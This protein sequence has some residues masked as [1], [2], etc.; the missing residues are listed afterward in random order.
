MLGTPFGTRSAWLDASVS[1]DRSPLPGDTRCDVCVVGAGIAGLCSAY[2][3]TKA[4]KSVIVLDDGP[5]AGGESGRTTAHLSNE[6]DDRY[7]EIERTHGERAAR[8]C[9]DS[10]TAAITALEQIAYDEKID[11]EFQRLDGFLFLPPGESEDVLF[12][13]LAAAHRAG[14]SGV[15]R[16]SR[17]PAFDSGPALRFPDQGQFHP[18]KFLAG[19]AHA[20]EMKGCR[21]YTGTHVDDIQAVEQRLAVQSKLGSVYAQ[22]VIIATNSPFN[23]RVTMHTKQAAYRTY[24]IGARVARGSVTRALYWDT[25]DTPGDLDAP[26]HFVRLASDLNDPDGSHELLIVGGEDHHTGDAGS[27]APARWKK[28]ENWARARFASMEDVVQRWSGQI[29]EPVDAV[30]FIGPNPSGPQNVYICTGDSGMGMTHG[31]IAGLLLTDLIMDRPNPWAELYDPSRKPTHSL[32]EY[33]K[34]NARIAGK[35]SDWVKSGDSVDS[36][37]PGCGAVVRRG[38]KLLAVYRAETGELV[39][40]SA[41]CPHLGCI[42]RWNGAEK[43]WDCP[44]HGSRFDALGHVLNGPAPSDLKAH[45]PEA[46][47]AK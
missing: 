34:E 21:I 7:F 10:H 2:W 5:I 29:M 46:A 33:T 30:A 1:L 14:L 15:E 19:L 3:L 42:V 16:V 28:L 41:V 8:I 44:C 38:V 6:I 39:E 47:V 4:G 9:A 11:C 43:S 20:L 24:V 27:D 22:S 40:H 12:K 25:S 37:E 23:D 35:Y 18:L 32:W 13:E 45:S 17:V 26:Y 36:L 31:S